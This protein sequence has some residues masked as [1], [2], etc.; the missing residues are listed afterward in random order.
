VHAAATR[1]AGLAGSITV[2]EV[3]ADVKVV[4]EGVPERLRARIG[5]ELGNHALFG[6]IVAR[7][8]AT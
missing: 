3:E 7:R 4:L 6:T 1:F 2:T 8:S 5:D